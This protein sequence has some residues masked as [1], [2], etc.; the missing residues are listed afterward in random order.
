[1]IIQAN[2]LDILGKTAGC[3]YHTI[4]ADPPY[5]LGSKVIIGPDGKPIFKG[6]AKDFMGKWC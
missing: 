2:C 5:N 4:F 3:E 1:M 6:A